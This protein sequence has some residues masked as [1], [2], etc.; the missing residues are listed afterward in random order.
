MPAPARLA[1]E[2]LAKTYRSAT[3]GSGGRVSAM[4]ALADF[5]HTFSPGAVTALLGPSGSGKSTALA[6]LAG[7]LPADA[8]R[9]LVDAQDVTA[10]PAER[11]N[12]GLVFQNYALF[13]HL[14]AQENI[15]FGLRVRGVNRTDRA[16]RAR[17]MLDLVRIPG[18]AARRPAQLSGGEQQRVAVARALAFE[19][20][21]LLMDEPLSAL[22]AKLRDELRSDL[23]ALL[24]RLEITTVYVTHDQT[25]AMALGQELIILNAGRIEQIG[26]P[27]EVYTRPANAFVA[28]FLGSANIF[29]G[30]LLPAA[31]SGGGDGDAEP[32]LELPFA[33]LPLPPAAVGLVNGAPRACRVMIRPEDVFLAGPGEP[34]HACGHVE[35]A[36]FLG[37]RLRLSVRLGAGLLASP[38]PAAQPSAASAAGET[39]LVDLDVRHPAP[40]RTEPINLRLET[41]HLVV[42]LEGEVPGATAEP[43]QP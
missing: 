17:A 18:L 36:L 26:S 5:T 27:R 1:I 14:S 40:G 31:N 28:G 35:T 33:R 39:L 24:S 29:P 8:G 42:W 13:P 6:I 20:R 3:A 12:F 38:A 34:A 25:E 4:P 32:T 41:S 7:L 11:R 19:P 16:A 21:V 43:A 30:R 23:H 10:L 37:S 15:E 22:D 9:V 2:G